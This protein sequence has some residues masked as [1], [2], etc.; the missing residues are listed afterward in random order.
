[1]EKAD[2]PNRKETEK[3][4]KA[5]V[6]E[7]EDKAAEK[8]GSWLRYLNMILSILLAAE[9]CIL[10]IRLAVIRILPAGY[11]AAYAAAMLGIC[12]LSGF[13][14]GRK[15]FA[16]AAAIVSILGV[17][18]LFYIFAKV[19]RLDDTLQKVASYSGRETVQMAV[20]ALADEPAEGLADLGGSKTG[21]LGNDENVPEV[22]AAIEEATGIPVIY[23]EY[24]NVLAL[25]EALLNGAEKAIII[26]SAY[27][28]II[29]EQDHYE[30]F[31]KK[32]KIIYAVEVDAIPAEEEAQ[33]E[34]ETETG[35]AAGDE[36][37]KAL[38]SSDEN[39]LIIYISGIDAFGSVSVKSRSDV[40]ILMAL[41]LETG[42]IQ[43]ISTPRDYY[44]TLP[45]RGA[46]KLTHAGLYGVECSK[47]VL[48]GLYGIAIDY[49]VRVNFSGF[50]KI[51]DLLGGID[52]YSEYDFSVEPVRHYTVG[53][54]H[55]SGIEALAFARERYSFAEGD[56]QRG[57]N[58]MEVIKAVIARA[59]SAE[60]LTNYEEIL[61]EVSGCFQT[62]MPPKVVYDLVRYQLSHNVSWQVDSFTVR[63]T[64]SHEVTY[65]M[66][67]TTSYVML[68]DDEDVA[69]ARSLIEKVLTVD[70][71]QGV[72][73]DKVGN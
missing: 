25:A 10:G 6:S 49:Y 51:I 15:A 1:M 13:L 11:M 24:E 8:A 12:V 52:V 37:Q 14:A 3:G 22:K 21:Y 55:L 36:R 60:M 28:G 17:C 23:E 31:S 18:G 72:V 50:E 39:Q 7:G 59:A 29:S 56:V 40:N 63:G 27:I 33:A 20:V 54:N 45:D 58:Q 43:L 64:G 69:E 42:H 53:Y 41:N 5:V 32:V 26:N 57:T 2:V 38:L 34:R 46:D 71:W 70:A 35:H 65:S 47:Q 62:D 44:V 30:D 73:T 68:P 9:A 19:D 16:P 61:E 67:G 66:P 48:E 4:L